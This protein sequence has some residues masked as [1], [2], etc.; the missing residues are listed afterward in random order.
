MTNFLAKL[1][2]TAPLRRALTAAALSVVVLS[3][4]APAFADWH[5]GHEGGRE[6][7]HEGW[8]YHEGYREGFHGG[9]GGHDG[10]WRRGAWY[11]GIYVAP[12]VVYANPYY[13][14]SA[15]YYP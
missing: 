15:P 13:Y 4:A 5:D 1:G 11:P 14:R 10:Y 9:W 6:G 7:F 12:P 3:A 2:S 8:R